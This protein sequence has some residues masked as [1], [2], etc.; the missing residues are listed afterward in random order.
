MNRWLVQGLRLSESLKACFLAVLGESLLRSRAK[1][2]P[3]SMGNCLLLRQVIGGLMT[4]SLPGSVELGPSILPE[5]WAG[6]EW[7]SCEWDPKAGLAL[8]AWP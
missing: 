8:T 3:K 5:G 4:L 7:W 2:A 1:V 6:V